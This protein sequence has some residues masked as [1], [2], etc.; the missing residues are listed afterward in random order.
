MKLTEEEVYTI[1]AFI[2]N[3]E[4]NEIPEDVWDVLE[5]LERWYEDEAY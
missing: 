1:I 2:R 3:H 5:K 4:R